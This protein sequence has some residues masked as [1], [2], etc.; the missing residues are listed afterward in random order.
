MEEECL[1]TNIKVVGRVGGGGGGGGS[2]RG[3][4]GHD[5]RVQGQRS[6][7]NIYVSFESTIMTNMHYK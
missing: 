6:L 3:P 4:Q 7:E 2:A 1:Y 5:F